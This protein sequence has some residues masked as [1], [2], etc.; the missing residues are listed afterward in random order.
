MC[1][2]F[3]ACTRRVKPVSVSTLTRTYVSVNAAIVVVEYYQSQF[4]IRRLKLRPC[5]HLCCELVQLVYFVQCL[6]VG[7]A[8]TRVCYC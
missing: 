4:C 7:K 3:S 8:D 5:G 6:V 2:E 1:Y